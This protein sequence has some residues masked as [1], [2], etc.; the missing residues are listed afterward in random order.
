[1]YNEKVPIALKYLRQRRHEITSQMSRLVDISPKQKWDERA[2]KELKA[3]QKA[4]HK[5]INEINLL[6]SL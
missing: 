4:Y 2:K 6:E 3:L 5:T 1:M